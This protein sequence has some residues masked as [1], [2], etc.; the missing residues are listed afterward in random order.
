MNLHQMTIVPGFGGSPAAAPPPPPPPPPPADPPRRVDQEV[1]QA[2]AD[3]IKRS[4]IAAGIGGTNKTKGLLK[5]S[6]ATTSR[7]TLLG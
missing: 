4:K 2:R 6:D 7:R 3:E 1:Q 5:D